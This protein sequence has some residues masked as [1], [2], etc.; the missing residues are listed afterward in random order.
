MINH[1]RTAERE[2]ELF[3]TY[4]AGLVLTGAEVKGIRT[5]GIRLEGAYVKFLDG[6]AF[7]VNAMIPWYSFA[8]KN[9]DYEPH[10]TRPLLLHKKEIM[11]IRSKMEQK[12]NVTLVPLS[13]YPKGRRLKLEFAIGKGLKNWQQ[14]RVE[15]A[16]SEKKRDQQEMKEFLKK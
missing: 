13:V 3:D 9:D 4:E 10:K 6:K 8:G 14:K 7:L 16:K 12:G 2:Y 11:Q 1:N 15:Q 5:L